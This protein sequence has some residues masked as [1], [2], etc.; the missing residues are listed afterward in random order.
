MMAHFAEVDHSWNVLRVIVVANED[1]LDENDVDYID[2]RR[3]ST[4]W[5]NIANEFCKINDANIFNPSHKFYT[6]DDVWKKINK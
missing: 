4:D 5:Y 3:K 2:D 1:I 6:W